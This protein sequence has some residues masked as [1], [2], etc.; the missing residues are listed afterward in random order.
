MTEEETRQRN[1]WNRP[2][3]GPQQPGASKQVAVYG[4][5]SEQAYSRHAIAKPVTFTC[6]VC[7]T[8]KTEYRYP[9]K[10]PKYCSDT[11]YNQAASERNERRVAQQREKRRKMRESRTQM[12][13]QA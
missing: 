4:S 6:V 7:G 10:K 11:C 8:T 12:H 2:I 13:N 1:N 9:G 3:A 5:S